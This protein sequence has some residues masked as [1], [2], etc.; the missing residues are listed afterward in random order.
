MPIA[1]FFSTAETS[2]QRSDF[3]GQIS[4]EYKHSP[5]M[6]MQSSIV[7]IR[8]GYRRFLSLLRRE[9]MTNTAIPSVCWTGDSWS[10]LDDCSSFSDSLKCIG[11]YTE[12]S[13]ITGGIAKRVYRLHPTHTNIHPSSAAEHSKHEV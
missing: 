8:T 9:Q 12:Q 1:G 10:Y 3:I 6:H 7:A 2:Q 5:S 11:C 4:P 13:W